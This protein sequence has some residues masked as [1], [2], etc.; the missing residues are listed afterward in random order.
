MIPYR[1]NLTCSYPPWLTWTLISTNAAIFIYLFTLPKPLH[2]QLLFTFGLV[3]IRYTEPL[4]ASDLATTT[5][6]YLPF[7]SSMFIHGGWIHLIMNMWLLWI[8][9]DNVEDR[10]G[11]GRFLLFYVTCGMLAG[12]AQVLSAPD[13]EIPAVGASGAIAAVMGAYLR[14]FPHARIIL[15]VPLFFLPIFL[16]VTAIGFLGYWIIIQLSRAALALSS[17]YAEVGWWGHV[18]GFV[19]GYMLHPLFIPL[20]RTP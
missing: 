14:M 4:W 19:A 2:D 6:A 16:E 11:A 9:G 18:G 17:S 12:C 7:I 15:W 3:S 20:R 10:M 1:D 8:F 5:P 13:S